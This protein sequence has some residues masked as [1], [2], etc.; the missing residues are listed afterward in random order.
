MDKP[1]VYITNVHRGAQD[2][3]HY[4]YAEVRAVINDE[5]LIAASLDYCV[6]H[7]YDRYIVVKKG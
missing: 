4:L 1:L 6:E 2:R 3:S 5:V 7:A